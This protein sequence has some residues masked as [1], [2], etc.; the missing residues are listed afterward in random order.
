MIRLLEDVAWR[1]AKSA[2]GIA[3]PIL[4]AMGQMPTD[5]AIIDY[6][7]RLLRTNFPFHEV[8]LGEPAGSAGAGYVMNNADG[9]GL[10]IKVKIECGRTR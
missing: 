6:I 9:R 8:R 10:Y 3:Y 1:I 5:C 4:R 7:V 2:R